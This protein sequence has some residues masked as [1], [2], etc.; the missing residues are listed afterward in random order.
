MKLEHPFDGGNVIGISSLWFKI[1][2]LGLIKF[3]FV[4]RVNLYCWVCWNHQ[5]FYGR[6]NKYEYEIVKFT[7]TL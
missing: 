1:I 3:E 5:L 4:T 2:I 6:L 7:K